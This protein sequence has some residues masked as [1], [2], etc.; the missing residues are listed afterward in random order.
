[1]TSQRT[2]LAVAIAS[3][4]SAALAD[5]TLYGSID[6]TLESVS[7]RGAAN[8]AQKTSARPPASTPTAPSSASRAAKTSATA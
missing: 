8:S 1:M 5:V 7:A 4:S 2:L 3:L 6:E